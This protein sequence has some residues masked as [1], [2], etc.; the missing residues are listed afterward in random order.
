VQS[1]S[2]SKHST[3]VFPVISL[4]I[5]AT[6]WG[7]VWYP[8]RIAESYGMSGLWTT[9]LAYSGSL[10]I[11]L[12][13]FRTHLNQFKQQPFLLFIIA[14]SNGWLNV[15]FILAVIDGNV[16][17][18]ILLFYL[19]PVWSTLLGWLVLKEKISAWSVA[20]L[21]VAMAGAMTMLWDPVLGFPWPQHYTDWLAITAGIGFSISNVTVR[22]LQQVSI[23]SKTLAA[24]L[25]VSVVAAVWIFLGNVPVPD[26]SNQVWSWTL[27]IGAVMIIVMTLSVQYGVTHMPVYQSAVILL[28]ELIAAAL[29]AQWLSDEVTTGREWIGGAMILLAGYLSARAMMK[30]SGEKQLATIGQ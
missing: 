5:A 30:Q 13:F 3:P 10:L 6:L 25:G 19:S 28:F 4:L 29:S 15:A 18:V 24:W 20:T 22:K 17:R 14:I 2:A 7:V 23:G 8:L 27:L 26:V 9:L 1:D 21:I 16:V 11:G 12:A